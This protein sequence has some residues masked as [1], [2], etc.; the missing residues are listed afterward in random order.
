[1]SHY[2]HL[3]A[4]LTKL[5]KLCDHPSLIFKTLDIENEN[6]MN[7]ESYKDVLDKIHNAIIKRIN[8]ME[9]ILEYECPICYELTELN[10]G[11]ISK[12]GHLFCLECLD[13]L[14]QEKPECAICRGLFNKRDIIKI[15]AAL[16]SEKMSKHH[17]DEYE[18]Y[19][20]DD[21]ND[22]VDDE[23]YNKLIHKYSA[24]TH[25]TSKMNVLIDR[26]KYIFENYKNDKILVFSNFKD[27][28]NIISIR[29][30]QENIK[31]LT[32]CA[33]LSRIK[34]KKILDQFKLSLDFNVL[35]IS[36]KCASVGLNLMCANHIIFLDPRYNP[37]LDN[38]AIGRCLR[39]GQNKTVYVTRLIIKQ[40]IEQKILS[41]MQDKNK[42]KDKNIINLKQKAKLNEN[43]Y[44]MIFD[45]NNNDL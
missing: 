18:K 7:I 40:T 12:C 25:S 35:L 5:R 41:L 39:I 2:M 28:F 23:E 16:R 36:S 19:K 21:D 3:M 34:R 29:L 11:I 30:N 13:E 27:F 17:K 1:M 45:L 8:E 33:G 24:K 37:S 6:V 38:Q 20:D 4:I 15:D 9:S 31:Y 32:F 42:N 43:D 44:D 14:L 22:N 26:L 10:G